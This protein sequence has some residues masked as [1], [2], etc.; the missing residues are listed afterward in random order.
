M[1]RKFH[2][3]GTD[4]KHSHHVLLEGISK[5]I[6]I[7]GRVVAAIINASNADGV[8]FIVG[9]GVQDHVQGVNGESGTANG[10]PVGGGSSIAIDD[11]GTLIIAVD[12][13][14]GESGVDRVG[15]RGGVVVEGCAGVDLLMLDIVLAR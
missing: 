5:N 6:Q 15:N 7:L 3:H 2:L 4:V 8:T 14:R 12:G 9:A 10:N 13:S 1:R 11:V